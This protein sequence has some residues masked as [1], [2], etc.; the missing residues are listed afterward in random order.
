VGIAID[1]TKNGD[2]LVGE[3]PTVRS[4]IQPKKASI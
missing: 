3:L 1:V 2:H 4:G